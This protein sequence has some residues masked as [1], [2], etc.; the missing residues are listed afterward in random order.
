MKEMEARQVAFETKCIKQQEDMQTTMKQ[1]KIDTDQNQQTSKDLQVEIDAN[2]EEILE[3][4]GTIHKRASRTL[5]RYVD[6]RFHHYSTTTNKVLEFML[7]CDGVPQ[8]DIDSLMQVDMTEFDPQDESMYD[9]DDEVD[10]YDDD[11]E[12]YDTENADPEADNDDENRDP[13][14]DE[15][16]GR[17]NKSTRIA[18]PGGST[19]SGQKDDRPAESQMA[20]GTQ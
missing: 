19:V 1:M 17:I 6:H 2:Q 15:T 16:E 20:T 18:S 9:Y 10:E 13:L 3:A 4:L 11:A 5:Y 12:I 14:C 8:E 7:K